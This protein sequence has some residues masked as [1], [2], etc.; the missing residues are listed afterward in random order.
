MAAPALQLADLTVPVGEA[1]TLRRVLALALQ[2]TVQDFLATPTSTLAPG[3]RAL[4]QETA[5]LLGEA[6]RLDPRLPL[7]VVR[8]VTVSALLRSWQ[9][10]VAAGGDVRGPNAWLREGCALVLL[11]LAQLGALPA[12]GVTLG[13]DAHG[14]LPSLRSPGAGF[15]LTPGPAIERLRLLPGRVEL[16]AADQAWTLDLAELPAQATAA[17][18]VTRPYM[19]IVPGISLALA[20]NHPLRDHEAHPDKQGNA[21]DLGGHAPGA[22]VDALRA[23]FALVDRYLPVLAQEMRLLLQLIVP[24]GWDA[25]KHLSASYREALGLLYLTLHPQPMTMTEALIHEFQHNKLNAALHLDPLLHNA[26]SPLYRS[27][28]RPDARPLHGVVLAVH[29]FQPVALLYRAMVDD[30]HPLAGNPAF[31]GRFARIVAMNRQGAATVLTHARP[32]AA[33]AGL[34]AE[35]RALDGVMAGWQG[36]L[37]TLDG[38]LPAHDEHG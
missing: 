32:T 7:R 4:F 3:N 9:G 18:T 29:A 14:G 10:A 15:L 38:A 36:A 34:L 5:R 11:E 37:P 26:F 16:Q 8:P 23:A 20:D 2:R 22:W 13:R 12:A 27:P 24:V 1:R 6:A 25:E 30:G 28:V 31:L 35:M 21:L 33:G 19:P 17:C